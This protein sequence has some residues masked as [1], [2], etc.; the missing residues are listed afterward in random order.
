MKIL[1][2]GGSGNISW[3]CTEKLADIGNDVWVINRRKTLS[4]RRKF[5]NNKIN[6]IKMDINQLEKY[7]EDIKEKNFDVVIDFLCYE[8]KDAQRSFNVFNEI[9]KRYIFISSAANYDRSNIIYP[10]KESKCVLNNNWLYAKNKIDC[11]KYFMKKYKENNFP[12]TIIRPGQTYDTLLPDAVGYGDWT[13]ALRILN[14]KPIVVHGDGTSLWTVTHSSDLAEAIVQLIMQNKGIGEDYHITMDSTLTW[15]EITEIIMKTLK[16]KV[17]IIHIPSSVIYNKYPKLGE[18][19]IGHKM[20]CDFYDN[21]KIKKAINGWSAKI[22]FEE[23]VYNTINWLKEDSV[24][25]R[26]NSE[27]N[28]QIDNLCRL[29]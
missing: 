19:L 10:I 24:R 25:Q 2:I 27:L 12:I 26:V 9:V 11:E 7:R 4:T 3:H 15:N 23:G 17:P 29:I 8:L 21:S 14:G 13:N 20:W 6:I 16:R 22:S 5:N 18:Q 1:I 28:V